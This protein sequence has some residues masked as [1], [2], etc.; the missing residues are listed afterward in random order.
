M[1][2]VV[3][4]RAFSFIFFSFLSFFNVVCVCVLN[5]EEAFKQCLGARLG[6]DAVADMDLKTLLP[7]ARRRLQVC[8]C[9]LF[10]FLLFSPPSL[11]P[12]LLPQQAEFTA[13]NIFGKPTLPPSPP[14]LPPSPQE[15]A[16]EDPSCAV[17]RPFMLVIN[18][19]LGLEAL[20][21]LISQPLLDH[22]IT[23]FRAMGA[24][25]TGCFVV[26]LDR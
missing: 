19:T 14:S 7:G 15:L 22:N 8:G 21:G 16:P 1:R 25:T 23:S 24:G 18:Q 13:E 9:I 26:P 2:V 10:F 20:G 5:L 6:T 11:P 4:R 12:S 17:T 3:Y